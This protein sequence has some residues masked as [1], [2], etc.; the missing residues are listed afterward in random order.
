LEELRGLER[1]RYPR[2]RL[3]CEFAA[4]RWH[5]HVEGLQRE[6][7]L[8]RDEV[9]RA[10]LRSEFED[11]LSQHQERPPKSL[12]K[13]AHSSFDLPHSHDFHPSPF[14]CGPHREEQT[15]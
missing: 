9:T 13:F 3:E 12:S 10:A 8:A 2:G 5:W 15:V 7:C 11:V 4:Q 1:R 14:A 6:I